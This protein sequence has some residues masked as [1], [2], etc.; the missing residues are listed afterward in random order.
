MRDPRNSLR[1]DLA[2]S[3]HD[4]REAKA[5][6]LY[7]PSTLRAAL[8]KAAGEGFDHA[9]VPGP[10]GLNLT[11][12]VAAKACLEWL[13]REKIAHNW[14]PRTGGG[15]IEAAPGYDLHMTWKPEPGG[16]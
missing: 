10:D 3:A 9:T 15:G 5:A 11:E 7:A 2:R 14:T 8:T 12:T 6:N 13:T 16:R 4:S 1:A